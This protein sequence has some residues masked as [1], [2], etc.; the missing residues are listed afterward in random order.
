MNGLKIY[1]ADGTFDG[2]VTMDST[3]SMFTAARVSKAELSQYDADFKLPGIYLLLID[4]NTV[5][6]GQSCFDAVGSRILKPHSGNIDASW[7]T[8][9]GFMTA[10]R[11]SSN[12]FLYIENA[13]CE[14]VHKHYSKCLTSSPSK[15]N[16]N[17][18]Y[19]QNHYQ[20]SSSQ[21]HA[22]D[23]YIADIQFYIEKIPVSI[24][25]SA[26]RKPVSQNASVDTFYF[27]N[28]K[29]DVAG[30]AEIQIHLGHQKM[31][32]TIL[33]AG[34]KI[35]SNVSP[36]FSGSQRILAYRQQLEKNGQIVNRVLQQDIRFESQSGAGQFLNGTA[37]DG[38][39]SWTTVSGITLKN[40]L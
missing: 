11:I 31:R 23:Q 10:S 7:H 2:A 15:K 5:Y 22:C 37:F 34:S 16:C 20:L 30:I 35:S 39:S 21:I 25:P 8:V 36:H 9:F 28:Q 12:E 26:Y 40:L 4:D 1:L 29:R 27:N 14:Y 17:A 38:N 3:A 13:M 19:R 32:T 24:F 6:V 18:A 33:K